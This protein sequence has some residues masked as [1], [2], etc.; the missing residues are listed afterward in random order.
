VERIVAFL[1]VFFRHERNAGNSKVEERRRKPRKQIM[2]K[3]SKK[4]KKE[5][6]L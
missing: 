3:E 6:L 1:Q 5:S 2:K 4:E